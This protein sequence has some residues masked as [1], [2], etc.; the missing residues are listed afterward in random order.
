MADDID[1]IATIY[2]AIIDPSNWDEF[3]K[4]IVEATKSVSGIGFAHLA[5]IN[6]AQL[7]AT[8]N[9]DPFYA[10]AYVET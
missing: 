10:N 3:V 5:D 8:Y 2:D 4:R 6:T 7:T 9:I 1:L